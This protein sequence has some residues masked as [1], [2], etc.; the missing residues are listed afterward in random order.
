MHNRDYLERALI[1]ELLR[2]PERFGELAALIKADDLSEGI[3][4]ELFKVCRELFDAGRPID[5]AAIRF[6]LGDPTDEAW[7]QVVSY[8]NAPCGE[9]AEYARMLKE[10]K[11][12]D[13]LAGMSMELSRA[14][15]AE[16]QEKIIGAMADVIAGKCETVTVSAE[17]AAHEFFDRIGRTE[18]PDYLRW[19]FEALDKVSYTEP[20]D[21]VAIGGYPSSGKTMFALQ[22]AAALAKKKRVGF[23]SLETSPQKVADRLMC[24]LSRVPMQKIKR[25]DLDAADLAALT[26]AGEKMAALALDIIPASGMSVADIQAISINK[27]YDVVF[28][29][30]LQIVDSGAKDRYENV[31][32]TSLQLH[33]MAQS[34]RITVIALAQFKRPDKT[35]G[36]KPV[37]PSM[38]DFRESGQIEQ[39]I[40]LALL[41]Y[42]SDHNDNRS[43]RICKVAKNKEGERVQIELEFDGAAQTFREKKESPYRN[44]QT[45]LAEYDRQERRERREQQMRFEETAADEKEL[46]F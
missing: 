12:F 9:I 21:F 17:S 15:S 20:G 37:P 29:D 11:R 35:A 18:K 33:R 28:V 42:P 45:R 41:L 34:H 24:H 1:S 43:S 32:Q 36:K 2:A 27:R 46:P 23:F 13:A 31:T 38:A 7:A 30:Y 14:I 26:T 16:E 8:Y 19:G 40:D 4:R 39:D 44:L 6:G 3:N 22:V 10:Q 5:A 25:R